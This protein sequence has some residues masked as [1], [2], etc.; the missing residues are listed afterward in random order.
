[1]FGRRWHG[2]RVRGIRRAGREALLMVKNLA[3]VAYS[4]R[5]VARSRQFYEGILGLRAGDAFGDN[6]AEFE[7]GEAVFAIDSHPPGIIP[8]SSSGAM[9]EVDDVAATREHLLANGVPVTDVFESRVCH[10]AFVT[11]PDGNSF[12]IHQRK[13]YST[14]LAPSLTKVTEKAQAG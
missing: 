5:D 4:V 11:D 12:G 9:F 10:F 3:F 1:M 8:G 7:L 2:L 14:S 6:F 13:S